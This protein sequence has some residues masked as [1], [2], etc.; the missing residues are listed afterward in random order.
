MVEINILENA[1]SEIEKN[2]KILENS[3]YEKNRVLVR[4]GRQ[5]K[6]TLLNEDLKNLFGLEDLQSVERFANSDDFSKNK[7]IRV[8]EFNGGFILL[9]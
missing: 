4:N 5:I 7:K 3:K 8:F 2:V 1:I 6:L 9:R